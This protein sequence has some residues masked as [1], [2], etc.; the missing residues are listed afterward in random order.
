MSSPTKLSNSYPIE[1]T[2]PKSLRVNIPKELN[3]VERRAYDL[4]K[5]FNQ[6]IS[7]LASKPVYLPYDDST[8]WDHHKALVKKG[9]EYSQYLLEQNN[10]P[11][12]EKQEAIN[13]VN[14]RVKRAMAELDG[15]REEENKGLGRKI[16]EHNKEFGKKVKD[17]ERSVAK[18]IEKMKT[19]LMESIRN[20]EN[21]S[22]QK[23]AERS[24]KLVDEV[25][26]NSV[27]DPYSKPS[28][29]LSAGSSP[30][31]TSV[32]SPEKK[33]Q[34]TVAMRKLEDSRDKIRELRAQY[35]SST[36]GK[37]VSDIKRYGTGSGFYESKR[38][39]SGEWSMGNS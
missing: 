4:T 17:L 19:E 27:R 35:F 2:P 37:E 34:N 38:S 39:D 32:N 36:P 13:E 9:E 28:R 16:A 5:Q 18:Q 10:K 26:P 24:K 12:K 11:L 20:A 31:K 7:E 1:R 22:E 21:E 6:S 8:P 3:S 25:L 15:I 14:Q 23:I 33:M 29:P 30:T